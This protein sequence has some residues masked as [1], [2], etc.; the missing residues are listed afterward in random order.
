MFGFGKSSEDGENINNEKGSSQQIL[1][2]VL[3]LLLAVFGY[4]YFF[5]GI[6]KPRQQAPAPQPAQVKQP[7]PARPA[8][9]GGAAPATGG[10]ATPATQNSG[11]AATAKPA[12]PVT[13][14]SATTSGA[15]PA[16]T[17][18]PPAASAVKPAVAPPA[19]AAKPAPAKAAKPA[20]PATAA[21]A[22][23][24]APPTKTATAVPVKPAPSKAADAGKAT[25]KA[26]GKTSKTTIKKHA[27]GAYTL[28]IG[29]YVG[30]KSAVSVQAKLKKLG[31][32][33]VTRTKAL[34]SEPMNRLYL[35]S[36]ESHQSA[37]AALDDLK[38]FTPDGFLLQEN[39][40][41][42]VYAGSYF[43]EAKAAIEQ[44]RLYEKGF[45]LVMKKT[46][47]PV[48]VVR[49]TAGRYDGKKS[50]GRDIA[51][52]KKQGISPHLVKVGK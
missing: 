35:G 27:A 26:D 1:L 51:S 44:D 24:P 10:T 45:K 23:K 31:I 43:N 12:V 48:H 20:T 25:A 2:L 21:P 16:A 37:D 36:F 46:K 9:G 49:L 19:P 34:R 6:I 38:K 42:A 32:R 33:P 3:V 13:A 14:P 15:K 40:K 11:A 8:D 7:I 41:Y 39:G 28:V 29:E 52:L 47:A 22:A 17:P 18:A 30:E 5:T 50:A 4:L